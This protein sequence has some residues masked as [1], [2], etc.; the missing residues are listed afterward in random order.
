MNHLQCDKKRR[1]NRSTINERNKDSIKHQEI[2]KNE[3]PNLH[4]A[5]ISSQHRPNICYTYNR[6]WCHENIAKGKQLRKTTR[7]WCIIICDPI[8]RNESHGYFLLFCD[9]CSIVHSI[10]LSLN[11][12]K[13]IKIGPLVLK[14][15]QCKFAN[16]KKCH[17]EKSPN[18]FFII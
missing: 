5:F 16:T 4:A 2:N 18:A 1:K 14:F 9:F 11:D 8:S 12:A 15:W 13:M 3:R 10:D 17:F 7:T 6:P